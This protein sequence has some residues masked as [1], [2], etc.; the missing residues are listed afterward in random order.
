VV[1][2]V[3]AVGDIVTTETVVPR[4]ATATELALMVIPLI[5]S[6]K[7]QLGAVQSAIDVLPV[8]QTAIDELKA[9]F[10][11][12]TTK[13]TKLSD[14]LVKTNVAL[15]SLDDWSIAYD[16]SRVKKVSVPSPETVT[17]VASNVQAGVGCM[18]SEVQFASG[19]GKV[20]GPSDLVEMS[21]LDIEHMFA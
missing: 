1:G 6:I 10:V 3:G 4:V 12:L 21:I 7:V 5:K 15:K 9:G 13:Y 8:F 19:V 16:F 2:S 18:E 20:V 11:V 17:V 14:R